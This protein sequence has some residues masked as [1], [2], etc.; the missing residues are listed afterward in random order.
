MDNYV[1]CN[2]RTFNTDVMF[3]DYYNV[4]T[5]TYEC[6]NIFNK[7]KLKFKKPK[8][9]ERQD[10]QYVIQLISIK[11]EQTELFKKCMKELKDNMLIKGYSSYEQT[12]Y[13]LLQK[14]VED[15]N[16]KHNMKGS[17][18]SYNGSK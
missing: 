3:I 7:H 8:T 11:N 15:Y 12:A 18:E 4:N 14:I 16:E 9:F 13:E 10:C 17:I 6:E 5:N 2:K 1:I